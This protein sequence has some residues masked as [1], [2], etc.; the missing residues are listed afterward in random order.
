VTAEPLDSPNPPRREPHT[1]SPAAPP[2]VAET[3][4]AMAA[5]MSVAEPPETDTERRLAAIWSELIGVP[6]IGRR[7]DFFELGGHSLLA[8]RVLARINVMFGVRLALRDVFRAP[9]LELLAA[10][11]DEAAAEAAAS[12]NETA[13]GREEIL[14]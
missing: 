1:A 6:A 2:A 14:I 7:D 5:A 8:T 4:G 12:I 3:G 13:D 9:T 10:R 11:I